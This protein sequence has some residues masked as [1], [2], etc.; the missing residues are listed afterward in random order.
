MAQTALKRTP[1]SPSFHFVH[2][3]ENWVLR[4]FWP[5]ILLL[6]AQPQASMSCALGGFETEISI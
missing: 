3:G 6:N 2:D 1:F 4:Q 5:F